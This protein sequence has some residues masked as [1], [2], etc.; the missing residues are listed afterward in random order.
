MYSLS[1]KAIDNAIKAAVEEKSRYA[2]ERIAR[3]ESARA[4]YQ[5]FIADTMDN[6][7]IVAYRWVESN[8]HPTEDICDLYA[9]EDLHGMGAGV[10]P[11]DKAPEL[12]A[13]PHCLCHYEKVYKA[14][15]SSK[16]Y[17]LLRKTDRR[18]QNPAEFATLL[19]PMQKRNV[20][21]IA[22]K[23]GVNIRGLTI[24]IQRAQNL[25]KLSILGCTDYNNIGRVDL[26]P[27]A[28][29]DE[30]TLIKTVIHES[31]HVKQLKKYGKEYCQDNLEY[32]EKVAYRG[33]RV[34]WKI[35]SRRT[36]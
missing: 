31:L 29:T 23:Y 3:T 32:M 28:F 7:D 5:G 19:V 15:I 36:K 18:N 8:R 24:K 26:L 35:V 20:K 6:S 1:D 14:E 17:N 11:K 34:F 21:Q 16:E 25:L 27:N 9:K 4:W 10:F 33:E 13:H 30:E 22:R 2:A 12:P